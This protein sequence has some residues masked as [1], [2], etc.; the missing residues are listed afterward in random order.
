MAVGTADQCR[1]TVSRFIE[2]GVS[3]PILYPIMDDIAAVVD[4]FSGW[5]P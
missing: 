1:E 4:A 5:T 2:A 3:C